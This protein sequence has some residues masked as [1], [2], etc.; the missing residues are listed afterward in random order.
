V[1]SKKSRL[2]AGVAAAG[3]CVL[4]AA[5]SPLKMGSAAIVGNQR[6]TSATLDSD[7]SSLQGATDAG[8]Q[9]P[10]SQQPQEVLSWLIRFAIRDKT[11]SENGISV[12]QTQIDTALAEVNTQLQENAESNGTGYD[13]LAGTLA[14]DYGLPPNLL[15]DLGQFEAQETAYVQKVNGGKL[16]TTQT[17]DDNA[18]AKVTKADCRSANALHIQVSPQY[19]QLTYSTS[20]SLY[21]VSA[22]SSLLSLPGG[23][24]ASAS[25]ATLPSC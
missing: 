18:V 1:L 21:S 2:A 24:K 5:C 4:L 16:P 19:G 9:I 8:N 22:P 7:V 25:P 10:A 13:G 12:N 15:K 23:P 14:D 3:A 20:A 11:A 17:Q 6:I